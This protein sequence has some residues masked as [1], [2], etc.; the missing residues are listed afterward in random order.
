MGEDAVRPDGRPE[1]ST[2]RALLRRT[3][4]AGAIVWV[5]PAIMT[6][7]AARAASAPSQPSGG[8]VQ[9]EQ[10]GDECFDLFAERAYF[11]FCGVPILMVQTARDGAIVKSVVLEPDGSDGVT[12]RPS[13][14]QFFAVNASGNAVGQPFRTDGFGTGCPPD[15]P[16][17]PSGSRL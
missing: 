8:C 3:A 5:A 9:F 10:A 2:R 14:I 17:G 15:S 1:R 7:D 11:N 13:T 6:V 4:A 16:I 12:V